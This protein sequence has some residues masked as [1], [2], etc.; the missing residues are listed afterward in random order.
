MK[1]SEPP[2]ILNVQVGIADKSICGKC[3]CVAG[4]SGYCHHVVGLLFYMSHCKHLGLKSLPDELTCTSL[5]QMWSVPRQ[6]KIANKAIQDVMVK[7]P[8]AGAD[9]T[10]FVKSTLYSPTT[11]YPLMH[12]EIMT[13]LKPQPLMATVLPPASKMTSISPVA[14]SFGNAAQGSV[15]SYQQKL[16]KE[17]IIN[18]YSCT[19]FPDLPLETAVERFTN[20]VPVC[21]S[22]EKQAA[23]DSLGVTRDTA[24]KLEQQTISQSNNETW[25]H[26]REKRITASKFGKVAKRK[27]NFESLVTQLNP[28]RRVVTADMQR[29]IDME[30]VAAMAYANIAKQGKVNLFPSGLIINPRSPWLGCSPDRKVYDSSAE[31]NGYLL[32]L[33]FSKPKLSRKAQ[34]ILMEY[35]IFTKTLLL[36]SCH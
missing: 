5:P 18:D 2:H 12:S 16:S 26:L 7:K 9:Y 19:F 28:S 21:L 10:K 23:L 6:K 30:P 34:L 14:T 24:I 4:A 33:D 27:T 25:Y 1:K 3:S 15:L 22:A 8:Q 11:A 20:N 29:G 31:E 17:Y 32:D 36:S 13:S 35:L